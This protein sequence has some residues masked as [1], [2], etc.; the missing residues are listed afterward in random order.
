MAE[1]LQLFYFFILNFDGENVMKDEEEKQSLL[2]IL[3]AC[4]LIINVVLQICTN[5]LFLF[6][7]TLQGVGGIKKIG[8]KKSLLCTRGRG[9]GDGR[10]SNI[11]LKLCARGRGGGRGGGV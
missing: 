10:G 6:F 3:A 4:R 7:F 5:F 8:V 9:E 2:S 11:F 1:G